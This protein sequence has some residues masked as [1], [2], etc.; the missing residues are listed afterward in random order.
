MGPGTLLGMAGSEAD[1]NKYAKTLG[2]MTGKHARIFACLQESFEAPRFLFR[3]TEKSRISCFLS[4]SFAT[5][6]SGST[7]YVTGLP[8]LG[9]TACVSAEVTSFAQRTGAHAI[10][11]NALRWTSPSK[12]YCQ[13]WKHF[14]GSDCSSGEA[15]THL[16]NYFF[17]GG[18]REQKGDSHLQIP[19]KA[20]KVL[21]VDETDY[22]MSRKQE[23]LYNL[24]D[25]MHAPKSNLALI[26]ISNT[27]DLMNKI[28]GKIK[29]RAGSNV[30]TFKPYSASEVFEILKMRLGWKN[31]QSEEKSVFSPEALLFIAR[32]VA[33]FTSDVRKSFDLARRCLHSFAQDPKGRQKISIELVNDVLSQEAS[34]PLTQYVSSCSSMVQLVLI[35]ILTLKTIS[36]KNEFEWES[37]RLRLNSNLKLNNSPQLNEPQFTILV[38]RLATV[39][40]V[41]ISAGGGRPKLKLAAD[42]EELSFALRENPDFQKFGPM[43]EARR[44]LA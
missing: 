10:F 39:S 12:L 33:N 32:K 42:P 5:K 21:V 8:G 14:S 26:C 35:V 7:L 34:R 2:R 20:F 23:V 27:L 6:G 9:K 17:G 44:D 31:A 40:L 3:E 19:R 13:L 24:F 22:L 38:Q 43:V 25:W 36:Q 4:E 18:G 37:V 30:L 16:R 29:S 28:I 15:S 41:V 11:L 1:R